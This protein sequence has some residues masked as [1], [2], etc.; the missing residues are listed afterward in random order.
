MRLEE[1]FAHPGD[2]T[3][4]APGVLQAGKI[5]NEFVVEM[6]AHSLAHHHDPEAVPIADR[7]V[8]MDERGSTLV[9][10]CREASGAFLRTAV[11]VPTIAGCVPET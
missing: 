7:L 2:R 10:V 8:G 1:D 5:D 9:R 6:H 11:E 4:T 3:G